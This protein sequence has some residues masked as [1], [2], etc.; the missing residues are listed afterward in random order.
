[1]GHRTCTLMG[2]EDLWGGTNFLKLDPDKTIL[3][4]KVG[5]MDLVKVKDFCSSKKVKML[6]A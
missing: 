5:T 1:M 6:V 2:A 4:D 3:Q